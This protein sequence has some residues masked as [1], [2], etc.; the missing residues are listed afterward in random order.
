MED[1]VYLTAEHVVEI[2]A[3]IFHCSVEQ[4]RDRL[5]DRN[6]LEDAVVRPQSYAYYQGADLALQAAVLAHGIAE[7]QPF[8]EGNKRTAL[9]AMRTFL[10]LNGYQITAPPLLRARWIL[11]LSSGQTVD[12]LAESIRNS[13]ERI[14]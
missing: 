6:V 8:V 7:G 10:R 5:R 14:F 2:Y 4:A 1:V 3:V 13:L 9:E 11:D 12:N